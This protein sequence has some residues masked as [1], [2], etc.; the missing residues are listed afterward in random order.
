MCTYLVYTPVKKGSTS[1][2]KGKNKNRG[3]DKG[4]KENNEKWN[5]NKMR[6]R[7]RLSPEETRLVAVCWYNQS[8]SHVQL[9]GQHKDD[10]ARPEG[11]QDEERAETENF[12]QQIEQS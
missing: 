6:S 9:M 4:N 12:T 3:G 8:L 7:R 5:K 1:T 10:K 2:R 11:R